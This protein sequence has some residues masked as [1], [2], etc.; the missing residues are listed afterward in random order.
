[1]RG[2]IN[3]N[4]E[5]GLDTDFNTLCDLTQCVLVHSLYTCDIFYTT[6]FYLTKRVAG[7]ALKFL[8]NFFNVLLKVN[9]LKFISHG[10]LIPAY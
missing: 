5:T 8:L 4:T 2:H 1:M 9:N 6:K 7:L 10:I 3:A